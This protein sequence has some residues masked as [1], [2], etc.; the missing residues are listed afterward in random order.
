VLEYC[1]SNFLDLD[2][3]IVSFGFSIIPVFSHYS[4]TPRLH[5][6]GSYIPSTWQTKVMTAVA[7]MIATILV[8]TADV[9]AYPTAE[10]LL[11]HCMPLRQPE[12]A[13]KTPKTAL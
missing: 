11:P 6:S 4:I 10:A 1:A 9:A 3:S 5:Y 7:T 2:N 13:T 12:R 8:T